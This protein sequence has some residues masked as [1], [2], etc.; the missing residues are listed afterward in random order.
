MQFIFIDQGGG[1]SR[2]HL[3]ASGFHH[4]MGRDSR[5]VTLQQGE[6][7]NDHKVSVTAFFFCSEEEVDTSWEPVEAKSALH[8]HSVWVLQNGTAVEPHSWSKIQHYG[9]CLSVSCLPQRRNSSYPLPLSHPLT[10]PIT[11]YYQTYLFAAN[12][13]QTSLCFP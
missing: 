9:H 5:E 11:L 6:Q 1:G 2:G 3:S 7:H 8:R 13:K 10:P 4:G 12:L